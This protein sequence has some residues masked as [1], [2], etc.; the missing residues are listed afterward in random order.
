MLFLK[1]IAESNYSVIADTLE[2]DRICLVNLGYDPND[3][4]M[5][6]DGNHTDIQVFSRY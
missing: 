2:I 6:D 3:C 1:M 4:K 5:M